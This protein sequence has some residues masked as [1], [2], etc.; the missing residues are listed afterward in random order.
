MFQ[1]RQ[2]VQIMRIL[3]SLSDGQVDMLTRPRRL[4][5]LVDEGAC[6]HM[7]T[8]TALHSSCDLT[9]DPLTKE[10]TCMAN[11]AVPCHLKRHTVLMRRYGHFGKVPTSAALVLREARV[12]GLDGLRR[13]VLRSLRDPASRARALEEELSKAWRVHS[14]IA[15]MFL[16]TL[17]T[18]DLVRGT[19]PW[20][21]GI[22]WTHFVVIDSNVDLFLSSIG[23]HG[24]STYAAR[25]AFVRALAERID[26]HR[27]DA[28][29]RSFNPR[30]VQ[31]A[32]YLFMSATNRRAA[33]RDCS[34][35]GARA[36]R[37]CP[38]ALRSRC[39]VRRE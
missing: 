27:L 23:Y 35:E 32:M 11:P 24:H 25:R 16:S 9:K 38:S 30:L 12:G 8:T 7:R 17:A 13:K 19:P 6:A 5:A 36:C 14:K 29:L 4:L 3:R 33:S 28:R 34:H 10:G 21:A 1:R 22:D 39:P 37:E 18:P 15:C 31:Q 20:A 2:D 26:L